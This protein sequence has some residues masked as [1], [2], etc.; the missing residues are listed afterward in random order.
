MEVKTSEGKVIKVSQQRWNMLMNRSSNKDDRWLSFRSQVLNK[1]KEELILHPEDEVIFVFRNNITKGLVCVSVA[2]VYD[3]AIGNEYEGRFSFEND[4][5][6]K[7]FS[8]PHEAKEY[9]M[10]LIPSYCTQR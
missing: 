8:T 4:N 6:A 2:K 10:S 3:T 5:K 9:V 7:R 1:N